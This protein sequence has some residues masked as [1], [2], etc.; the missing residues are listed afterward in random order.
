MNK[1]KTDHE[2]QTLLFAVNTNSIDAL[3]DYITVVILIIIET[4]DVI[5]IMTTTAIIIT[6]Y[7]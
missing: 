3:I 1:S 6:I 2:R 4:I 7:A 5:A